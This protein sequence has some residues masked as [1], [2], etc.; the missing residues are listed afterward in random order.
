MDKGTKIYTIV[1]S[2]FCLS[3]VIIFLYESPKVQD[4]NNQLK[5]VKEVNNFPY[6]FKVLQINNGIAIMN[7]PV[8][9]D[10]PC[11]KVIAIIFPQLK[12]KSLLS[13]DY[14]TAQQQMAKVQ[15][16]ASQLV[17]SDPDI[18][19]IVWQ[20]DKSWLIQHGV[21]LNNL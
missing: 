1:L 5:N 11:G 6:S 16:L 21:S 14:Q 18:H 3:I 12:G 10:L 17:K 15:M 2:I 8:S 4:L 13:P 9:V 20:L 19:K 7:S